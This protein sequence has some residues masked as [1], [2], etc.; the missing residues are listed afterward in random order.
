MSVLTLQANHH[1]AVT[2]VAPW[3]GPAHYDVESEVP[4]TIFVFDEPNFLAWKANQPSTY[5]AAAPNV[6]KW[7]QDVFLKSRS[8]WFLVLVNSNWQNSAV[9]YNV[10]S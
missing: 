3:F 8:T 7:S 5:I 2:Y 1:L 4:I 9:Y 10:R 6:Q